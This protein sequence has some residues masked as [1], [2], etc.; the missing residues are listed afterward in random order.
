MTAQVAEVQNN[1]FLKKFRQKNE[2]GTDNEKASSILKNI[3]MDEKVVDDKNYKHFF[4]KNFKKIKHRNLPK[5][6]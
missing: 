2:R 5:S 6:I 4:V 3:H 1:I